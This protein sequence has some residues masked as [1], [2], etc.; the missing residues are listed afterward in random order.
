MVAT[1]WR[2]DYGW[3]DGTVRSPDNAGMPA[4]ANRKERPVIQ[5]LLSACDGGAWKDA[6]L[7][8]I[9]QREDGAVEVIATRTDGTRLA[10]EHTLIQPFFEEKFDSVVFMRAFGRI[11]KNPALVVPERALDVIIPVHAI[12][13]GYSW[14]GVGQDVLSWLLANHALLPPNSESSHTVRVGNRKNG[15][16]ALTI[17]LRTRPLPGMAGSC[18]MARLMVPGELATVVETALLTKVPK[19]VKTEAEER[20]LLLERDQ[21]GLGDFEVYE[22]VAKLAP[23]HAGMAKI[24]EVWIANTSNVASRGLAYFCLMDGDGLVELLTFESG[25]LREHRVDRP[26]RG[27]PWRK[28]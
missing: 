21:I 10:L 7:D 12:S 16:L 27:P 18:L 28:L 2:I 17:T 1:G 9:E 6:G 13:K 22:E 11:E 20:I 5:M 19:L 3:S 14:E 24:D 4:K 8:W 26:Y 25:V 15:P 23:N